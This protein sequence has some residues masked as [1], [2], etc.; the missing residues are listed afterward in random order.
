MKW[1]VCAACMLMTLAMGCSKPAPEAKKETEPS[2]ANQVIEDVV[3]YTTIKEG[4]RAAAKIR[5]INAKK[6]ED[7][8]EAIEK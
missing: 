2:P 8:N 3:G 7:S 4:R 5:E 1:T 6:R